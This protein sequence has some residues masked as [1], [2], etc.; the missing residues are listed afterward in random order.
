[1]FY[2]FVLRVFGRFYIINILHRII[3]I[4]ILHHNG[5]TH[6][7]PHDPHIASPDSSPNRR[8]HAGALAA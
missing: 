8:T 1:M 2:V 7:A 4:I 3:P 6:I 5:M